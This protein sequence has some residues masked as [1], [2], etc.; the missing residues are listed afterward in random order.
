M[1]R[2]RT[3]EGIGGVNRPLCIIYASRCFVNVRKYVTSSTAAAGVF[4]EEEGGGGGGDGGGGGAETLR[5]LVLSNENLGRP[6]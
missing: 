4:D 3:V 6:R 1:P 5:H 2:E